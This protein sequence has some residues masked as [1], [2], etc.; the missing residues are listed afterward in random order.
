MSGAK[1]ASEQTMDTL[2][3][4]VI[5]AVISAFHLPEKESS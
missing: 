3:P 1:R 2:T 5:H 4:R